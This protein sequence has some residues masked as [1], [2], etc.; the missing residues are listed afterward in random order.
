MTAMREFYQQGAT[1]GRQLLIPEYFFPQAVS[2][3]GMVGEEKEKADTKLKSYNL[4]C[5]VTNTVDHTL[6]GNE[7][8]LFIW[9]HVCIQVSKP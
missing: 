1:L 4:K 2:E 8:C 6:Q 7:C 3:M 9:A 5:V